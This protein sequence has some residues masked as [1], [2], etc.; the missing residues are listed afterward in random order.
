MRELEYERL[1]E[2]EE[3]LWWLLAL[4]RNVLT[5]LHRHT[6]GA[7]CRILDAGCGTGGM[8]KAI[9]GSFPGASLYGLDYSKSASALARAKSPALVVSGS[10]N[11]LPYADGSFDVIVSLDVL[12]AD[13]ANPSSA[14]AEFRRI[15]RP[16]GLLILNLAAYQWMLSYHDKAVG[17]SRRFSLGNVTA[18]LQRNGLRRIQGTYWNTFLFPLMVLRRKVLTGNG[19]GSDVQSIPGPVDA[20]FRGLVSVERWIIGRGVPLPFGGSVL[21]V[22]RK[23]N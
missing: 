22:A 17:Q 4:R 12:N 11:E 15:L 14:I 13:D 6:P 21:A 10:V 23:E 16:G 5:L 20:L 18:L 9:A 19:G 8:L 2:L 7:R 3:S 1:N